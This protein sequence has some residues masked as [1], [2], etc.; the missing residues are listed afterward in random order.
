MKLHLFTVIF[1]LLYHL[2]TS[3]RSSLSQ[4]VF[5]PIQPP[6][7]TLS[8]CLVLPYHN[9]LQL[10]IHLKSTKAS[11]KAVSRKVWKY[12]LTDYD[13]ISDSLDS[14]KWELLLSSDVDIYWENWRNHFMSIMHRFIPHFTSVCSKCLPWI[15]ST[16][17]KAIRKRKSLLTLT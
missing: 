12:A 7:L 16:V 13:A 17:L 3:F 5:P 9:G 11:D 6:S 2:L 15:N 8:L 10:I 1:Y 4:P 14:T